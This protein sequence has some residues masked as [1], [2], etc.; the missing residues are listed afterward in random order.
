M[1]SW[2]LTNYSGAWLSIWRVSFFQCLVV[3]LRCKDSWCL[4]QR[5]EAGL[6]SRGGVP[7]HP[8]GQQGILPPGGW[9][10]PGH[11]KWP[12]APDLCFY[13]AKNETCSH[14]LKALVKIPSSVVAQN[15]CW[16]QSFRCLHWRMLLKTGPQPYMVM[17]HGFSVKQICWGGSMSASL[18]T[19]LQYVAVIFLNRNSVRGQ[20][21]CSDGNLLSELSM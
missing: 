4:R 13:W 11:A 19:L 1:K 14:R 9:A 3:S 17:C 2:Q 8:G 5:D 20:H 16:D 10:R 12:R 18:W 6:D 21:A 7:A 15:F